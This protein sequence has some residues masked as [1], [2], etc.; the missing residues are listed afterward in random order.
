MANTV[1]PDLL[2]ERN[3]TSFNVKEVT[4]FLD[5]GD[6][7]RER[8]KEIGVYTLNMPR[9]GVYLMYSTIVCVYY[10]QG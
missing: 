2:S 7:R 4:C 6:D 8:R 3:K 9:R 1:N 5:G 10:V